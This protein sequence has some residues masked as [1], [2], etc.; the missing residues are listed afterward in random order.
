MRHLISITDLS[1]EDIDGL[2]QVSEDIIRHPVQYAH[3]AE[4]KKLATLFFELSTLT[5]PFF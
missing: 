3:R 2:L 5:L 1:V 4:G